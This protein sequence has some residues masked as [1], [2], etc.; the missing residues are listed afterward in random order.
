MLNIKDARTPKHTE[1]GV[2]YI[3]MEV[4]F[5]EFGD[6][7]LPF[8]AYKHDVEVHGRALWKMAIDG[9]MGE[10][11]EYVPDLEELALKVRLERDELLRE[12]DSIVQN[13]LRFMELQE[14]EVIQ[15]SEYR[16]LLLDVPQQSTFPD[17]AVFPDKP[18]CLVAALAGANKG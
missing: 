7:W 10:I 17:S 5:E 11:Q 1:Y 16:Q 8:L 6:E 2:E 13:P 15:L 18:E 4:Q 14:D 3:L 9:L 12:V